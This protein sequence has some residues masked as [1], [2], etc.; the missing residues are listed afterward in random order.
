MTLQRVFSVSELVASRP[1]SP[2]EYRRCLHPHAK[3]I[4]A[5]GRPFISPSS[6]AAFFIRC[7][8]ATLKHSDKV[9]TLCPCFPLFVDTR[10]FRRT[11][12]EAALHNWPSGKNSRLSRWR[13]HSRDPPAS[14]LLPVAQNVFGGSGAK[15]EYH[16]ADQSTLITRW[17]C[18]N[19]NL[20]N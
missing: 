14:K 8:S 11:S 12:S 19:T 9:S 15:P 18:V 5:S 16:G 10:W 7:I 6:D 1:A 13:R 20:L 2:N 3:I 17:P 4:T